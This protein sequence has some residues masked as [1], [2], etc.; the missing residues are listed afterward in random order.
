MPNQW[1]IKKSPTL[2]HNI[3]RKT[4]KKAALAMCGA[5]FYI[6]TFASCL[7][8]SILECL[9]LVGLAGIEPATI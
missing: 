4:T 3:I 2:A 9:F 7:V 5:A 6:H 8:P 1:I